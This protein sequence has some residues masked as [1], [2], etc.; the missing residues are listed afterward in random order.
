MPRGAKQNQG[1]IAIDFAGK[2]SGFVWLALP[3]SA[4]AIAKCPARTSHDSL[5]TGPAGGQ[6]RDRLLSDLKYVTDFLSDYSPNTAS[7]LSNSIFGILPVRVCRCGLFSY[8]QFCLFS[9]FA[10]LFACYARI[11]TGEGGSNAGRRPSTQ[12]HR[13][14]RAG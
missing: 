2:L 8:A 12:L 9:I 11:K 10:E 3:Y 6:A 14:A 1:I 13:G 4:Q 7:S 5:A